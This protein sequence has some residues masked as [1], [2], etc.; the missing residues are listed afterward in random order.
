MHEP[1]FMAYELRLLCHTKPDFYAICTVFMGGGG[2]LPFL[3]TEKV[4]QRNCVT[5][6]LPN[7]RLNFL[8]RF[9]SKP[10]FYCVMTGRHPR[11]VQKNLWCCSCDFLAL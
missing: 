4:P 3:E 8:V 10:L 7:V 6:I 9:A 1:T 11:I 2:G 5:K